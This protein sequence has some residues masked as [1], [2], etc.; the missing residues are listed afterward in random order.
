M[1]T[2]KEIFKIKDPVSSISHLA[3]AIIAIPITIL[4]I[5]KGAH[6]GSA[7]YIVS[8]AIF[9]AALFL[10]YMAS[11]VYHYFNI[12]EKVTKLLK[13]IDHMMIFVLIAGTYTPIC[14]ITLKG[15]WGY[16]ILAVAWAFAIGGIF[17]KLFWIGAPRILSTAIYVA[18]GWMVVVAIYPLIKSATTAELV[19]LLLGGLA[20]T[21]GAVIYAMKWF[22]IKLKMVGFHEIFHFFV[23]GGSTFHVAL[24]F[25]L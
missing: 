23:L 16:S 3:G 15:P 18:M 17:L 14:L 25:C 10:L 2:I 6:L 22:P 13:R 4:L 8:F 20:Y 7:R 12:S 19:L 24:M 21:F 5:I 1:Q 9:G 11:A